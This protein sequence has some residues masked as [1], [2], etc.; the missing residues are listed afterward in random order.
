M[1]RPREHQITVR[2]HGNV[3]FLSVPAENVVDLR[4]KRAAHEPEEDEK[5][6]VVRPHA[7]PR[8]IVLRRT[9]TFFLFSILIILPILGIGVW[10]RARSIQGEVLGA[11]TSG[12]EA[13]GA[14]AA[15]IRNVDTAIAEQEFEKAAESFHD[16]RSLLDQ[17]QFV[18]G[19]L[20]KVLPLASKAKTGHALT[21]AGESLA[22]AGTAVVDMIAP[23]VTPEKERTVDFPEMILLVQQHLPT[24]LQ[25]VEG[26]I[27]SLNDVNVQ[28]LPENLRAE[29]R[30]IQDALPA[31]TSGLTNIREGSDV[32]FTLLGGK[33]TKRYL[34]LF[35]NN[36]E[37]RPTGGFVSAIALVD[38]SGG[39]VMA[40]SVPGG[41]AY[42]LK[43]QLTE[44]LISPEPLHLVN[45]HWQL[46][47]AN[48]WPDFPTSAKK[49]M[50]F[51]EKSGGP[52]VDGVCAV[53]PDLVLD[54][55]ET[56]GPVE[57][58]EY[59]KVITQETFFAEVNASETVNPERPKQLIADL[60]PRVLDRLFHT[61]ALNQLSLLGV[62]E[63]AVREKQLLLYFPDTT[64][65]ASVQSLG[66]GGAVTQAERD[67]LLVVDTNIGGGKTDGVIDEKIDHE[68]SIEADGRV[69]DTV[70]VTRTH[71]GAPNDP[72][73]GIRNVNFLRVY[74]PRG[75]T[76]LSVEGYERMDPKR[77]LG[78]DQGY[79]VDPQ[80]E[81]IEGRPVIDE[82][83]QTR[84]SEEFGYTVFANWVGVGPGETA[85]FRLSYELPFRIRPQRSFFSSRP[86]TY[87]LL[88]QKQPGTSG[89]YV[90]STVRY[91]EQYELSWIT[92]ESDD[93]HR[94][95]GFVR[96]SAPLDTD[97]LVGV[98]LNAK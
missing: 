82:L 76:L 53:T 67:A 24:A 9:A 17:F 91:P 80:I 20:S 56:T 41:G 28:D 31:I 97:L 51:Y 6:D 12:Y 4:A 8:R 16:A 75:S 25:H 57:L 3:N 38:V 35:Q 73:T 11:S 90:T 60:L 95:N 32:L 13:L 74:V 27:D 70:T 96:Y 71:H 98:V 65:E 84:T 40:L 2:R 81:E 49:V 72:L 83:T 68:A 43:G 29:F 22:N 88:V 18:L 93:L 61:P 5:H 87:S 19:G 23:L 86:A 66:W 89:R 42:D 44:H 21:A 47:D 63:T 78:P 94:E 52:T 79:R 55:L 64:L 34:V 59:G 14:A 45:P 77:F 85:V 46:Q 48:W 30:S 50:W 69:V 7:A 62:V 15:A 26:A 92:P 58:P 39:R 37:L 33:G 1:K 54:V 10:Q 36:Q